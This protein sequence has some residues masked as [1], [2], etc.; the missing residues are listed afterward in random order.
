[1]TTSLK[2][3]EVF[4]KQHKHI[5][6]AIQLLDCSEDFI[7]RNFGLYSY[8]AV[9][10]KRQ[11]PAYEITKDGFTFLAM[12]FTGAKAAEFKEKYI[13][14]F[15][16]MAEPDDTIEGNFPLISYTDPMNRVKSKPMGFYPSLD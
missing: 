16:R 14:E 10:A 3:A 6:L 8:R 2:V 9:G 12:G 5:L 7:E 1:M 11:Y 15:N 4:G 13:A